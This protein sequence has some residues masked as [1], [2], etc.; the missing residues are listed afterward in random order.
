MATRYAV[1]L[2][3]PTGS[4][5][6]PDLVIAIMDILQCINAFQQFP[7]PCEVPCP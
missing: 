3:G 1:D 6:P 2:W 5:C 7:F 4:D